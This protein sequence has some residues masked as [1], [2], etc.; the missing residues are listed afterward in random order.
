M[1]QFSQ[2]INASKTKR[3]LISAIFVHLL[4]LNVVVPT[5]VYA[6]EINVTINGEKVDFPDQGPVIV[7]GRVLV[8]ARGVFEILGYEV[9]WNRSAHG[10]TLRGNGR[11]FIISINRNSFTTNQAKDFSN[12]PN[13]LFVIG[14]FVPVSIPLDVPAQIINGRTMLPIRAIIE[15][16]GY[17][18]G[19]DENTRT[20]IIGEQ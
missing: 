10:V 8:P 11:Q 13:D 20:V 1:R 5:T 2:N 18:V 16:L 9:I 12:H 17:H 6:D 3:L 15:N 19:W 14:L 4:V 7:E